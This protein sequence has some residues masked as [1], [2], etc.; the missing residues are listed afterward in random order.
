MADLRITGVS[1]NQ[2]ELQAP[3]GTRHYLEITPDLLKALKSREVSLPANSSPREIQQLVR[4]GAT[5]EEVAEKTG[6][7]IDLVAKFAKPIIAELKHVVALARSIR[8]SLAGD[9]FAEPTLVE[10]GSVM[11]ERL[12]NNGATDISWSAKRSSEGEWLVSIRFSTSQGDGVATWS[13]DPKQ[14]FLAPENEAALQLSNGV[15]VSAVAKTVPII[16]EP[17]EIVVEEIQITERT[18]SLTV[19]PEITEVQAEEA[20]D[21]FEEPIASSTLRIV[22]ELVDERAVVEE[23]PVQEDSAETEAL[24]DDEPLASTEGNTRPQATSGWAEVLF[25]SKDDEEEKN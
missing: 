5:L 24:S 11:D 23:I 20:E 19:V 17:E 18:V 15:P 7:D 21:L 13:F 6:A 8:L 14:L 12:V 3:D 1:N 25:G 16:S 22:E 4:L 9:R 2:L 10:F